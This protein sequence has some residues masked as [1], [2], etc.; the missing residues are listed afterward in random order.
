[1]TYEFWVTTGL[2][3]VAVLFLMSDVPVKSSRDRRVKSKRRA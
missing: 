3:I 2:F 1:M